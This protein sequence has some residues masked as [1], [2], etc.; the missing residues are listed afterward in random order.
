M[1]DIEKEPSIGISYTVELPNKK[2]L[3]M[4]SFVPRDCPVSD[5]DGVLD[6]I[7]NAAERQ[8]SVEALVKAK[9]DLVVQEKIALDHSMRIAQVDENI[10]RNWA[11]GNRRGDPRLS[12]KDEAAQKQ[13]HDHGVEIQ[14]MIAKTKADIADYQAKIGA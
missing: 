4:Q 2:G 12:P 10:K 8:Y 9:M 11:N 3:V 7:R 13:A 1:T 6:K 5:L 14:R